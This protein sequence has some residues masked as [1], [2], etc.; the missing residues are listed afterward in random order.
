MKKRIS[1]V[2]IAV[3]LGALNLAGQTAVATP[4]S[5]DTTQ[6]RQEIE[7]MKKTIAA[8]EER[9]AAQE[10]TAQ[11]Q[12]KAK[13]TD[14]AKKDTES[15]AELQTRVKD[16][17]QRLNKSERKSGLDRL[18]WS[19]D[20]RVESHSIFGSVPAHYDGMKLQ[21]LVVKTLW[22]MSP[23]SQGGLGMAFD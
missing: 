21:N 18:A 13:E 9:L 15:V 1:T 23:T 3:F 4:A 5:D 11:E 22:M 12:Q 20:F 8:M 14:I 6:L 2:L 16:L 7:Q 19:G 10:K 17:S